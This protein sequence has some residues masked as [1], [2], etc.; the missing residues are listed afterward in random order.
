VTGPENELALAAAQALAR[1]ERQ[2]LSPLLVY[3]PSGVGKSRLV[4]GLVAE[5]RLRQPQSVVVHLD[6]QAFSAAYFKAARQ[7][8]QTG[9]FALRHRFRSATLFVLEDLESLGKSPLPA[10]ELV[11][12]L[13]A[14]DSAG[15]AVVIS[16]RSAPG[17]WSPR[18][19]PVRL[20]S[21]LRGGVA[22]RI[23]PPTLESLRRYV[24][25][26]TREHGIAL[27]TETVEMLI[28]TAHDYRTLNG[29]IARLA[30]E[31]QRNSGQ[32]AQRKSRADNVPKGVPHHPSRHPLVALKAQAVAMILAEE[33]NWTE[34]CV[35]IETI[36][37]TAARQFGIQLD[38]L[39]GPSR[40][41]SVVTVRHLAMYLART[42]TGS[43]FAVIGKYFGQRDPSTVR[44]ACK[45]AT[46]R[47]DADPAL[48]AVIVALKP[49]R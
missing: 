10:D 32:T 28:V 21:R 46:R 40:R 39:R 5:Y 37:R 45:S 15:A 9:W 31:A 18:K 11:R 2:G 8:T 17:T 26:T 42:R 44:H 13:D 34:S 43:S 38:L 25:H 47:L 1:G 24:I 6:A 23:E 3:G 27:Q 49:S 14:L 19:W 20:V 16:A 48:S 36:A 4:A 12:T 41:A 29:W 33:L 7:A 30:E 22:A 35:T